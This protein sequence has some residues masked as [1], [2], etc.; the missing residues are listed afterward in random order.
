MHVEPTV[1]GHPSQR[2]LVEFAESL[3]DRHAPVSA[4]MAA[5][6]AGCSVC[7]LEVKK[8]R[9]SFELAAMARLPEPSNELTQRIIARARLER[10]EQPIAPQHENALFS[11]FLQTAAC[12]A[13]TAALACLSF[14]AALNDMT[15]NNASLLRASFAANENVSQSA[16]LQE[17]TDSVQALSSAVSL[18]QEAPTSPYEL[19]HRRSLNA[20]NDDISAALAAL[21]RNPGCIRAN[22]VML[23]SVERQLEGLRNLYL[24][25]KL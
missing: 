9:A 20:L 17:Q 16:E 18:Q 11:R 7:A 13:A 25:R 21:E 12:F 23:T 6:V 24:D 8:I 3:V 2:Q 10:R 22:Q 1:I 14:G 15:P 19:G 5:H 4:L